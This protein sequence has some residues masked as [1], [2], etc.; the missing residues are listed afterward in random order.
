M[1]LLLI[2]VVFSIHATGFLTAAKAKC[3]PLYNGGY[4]GDGG[5]NVKE[6]WSFNKQTNHCQNVMYKSRCRSSQNCYP[7][8]DECEENCDPEVLELL[9]QVQ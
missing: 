3:D 8:S 9:K 6:G 5:A 4:G 7:T 1:K 2:A